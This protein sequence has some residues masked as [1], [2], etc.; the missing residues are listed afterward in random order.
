MDRPVVIDLKEIIQ[1]IMH[2]W[3]IVVVLG[4][5]FA[6]LLNCMYIYKSKEKNSDNQKVEQEVLDNYADILDTEQKEEVDETFQ[7]YLL[8]KQQ[9][10]M[11]LE[12]IHDSILMDLN[13]ENIVNIK[14]NYFIDN[15]YEVVYPVIDKLNNA[16]DIIAAF[17]SRLTSQEV[18]DKVNE[19]LENKIDDTYLKELVNVTSASGD[20]TMRIE[21]N[22]NSNELAETIS[23]VI[24]SE[25]QS[26]TET[27]REKFGDFDII[28]TSKNVTSDLSNNI[29][30]YQQ[31]Q[32]L[33]INNLKQ[34]ISNLGSNFSEE[35]LTYYNALVTNSK[36]D[37]KNSKQVGTTIL[38]WKYIILGCAFGI[39]IACLGIVLCYL[40]QNKIR[41]Y[42]DLRIMYDIYDLG[43]KELCSTDIMQKIS[44]IV[45]KQKYN[46]ICILSTNQNV[47]AEEFISCICNDLPNIKVI[48]GLGNEQIP[49]ALNELGTDGAAILV[50]MKNISYY[51]EVEKEM[52]L[53]S[54]GNIPIIGSI[55]L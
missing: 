20:Q 40:F 55:I 49:Q 43:H 13:K 4:I 9:Y 18:M 28:N 10:D 36:E 54:K 31:N 42:S 1:R 17:S 51:S 45:K 53:C 32:I 38:N 15:H 6:I 50:E 2:R 21:I 37:A 26:Y 25:V 46:E 48:A 14:L 29:L 52:E 35:Q 30:E 16:Q 33:N 19:K 23:E 22:A 27:E 3:L 47:K 11:N 44:M 8:Y 7:T 41:N 5:C 39:V 34:S 12:H 24:D